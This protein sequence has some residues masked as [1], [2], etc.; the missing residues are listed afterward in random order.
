MVLHGIYPQLFN[1]VLELRLSVDEKGYL[2]ANVSPAAF[3]AVYARAVGW[4]TAET[5]VVGGELTVAD[6]GGV[7]WL[8]CWP[9]T[10]IGRARWQSD[11]RAVMI[12]G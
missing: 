4:L 2:V 10:G 3:R 9:G 7:A 12:A 11:D 6:E 8:A 1:L 5:L